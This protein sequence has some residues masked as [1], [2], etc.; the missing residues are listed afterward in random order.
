M[1]PKFGV[2]SK[3]RKGILPKSLYIIEVGPTQITGPDRWSQGR[4]KTRW[5]LPQAVHETTL[6]PIIPVSGC[7]MT[8]T[9]SNAD[10]VK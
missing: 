7:D 8:L 2:F 1:E 3:D 6:G 4:E 10:K 5:H 9:A